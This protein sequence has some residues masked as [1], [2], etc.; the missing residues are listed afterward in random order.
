M[1]VVACLGDSITEGSPYWYSRRRRGDREGQWEH[2]AGL[3]HPQL[4]FLNYGIWGE[5]TDEIAGRF[6]H[7]VEGADILIV[8]GGINDI[9]QG[10]SVAAAAETLNGLVARGLAGDDAQ[11]CRLATPVRPDQAEASTR[12][13]V[14]VETVEDQPRTE[15]LGDTAHLEQRHSRRLEPERHFAEAAVAG[16]RRVVAVVVRPFGLHAPGQRGVLE[17]V[18]KRQTRH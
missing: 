17:R 2:W 13:D 16:E 14:E 12:L 1:P 4:A 11:Q 3:L 6:D 5:R 10:R 7:A 15:A 18:V 8:Q 9:A